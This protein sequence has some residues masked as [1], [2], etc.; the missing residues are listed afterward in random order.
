MLRSRRRLRHRG[1]TLVELLIVVAIIGILTAIMIP[2]LL[3]ALEKAKQKRTVSDIRNVGTSWMAW[4]TDQVSGAAAGQK[5]WWRPPNLDAISYEEL[6]N[7]LQPSSS[8]FYIAEV[9]QLDGWGHPLRFAQATNLLQ[10]HTVAIAAAC[11]DGA[12]DSPF[13]D[14]RAVEAFVTTDFDRDIV[15]SDGYFVSW[16]QN[17]RR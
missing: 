11:R 1:F 3:G 8:F 16:P 12:L 5:M 14:D 9:P 2:N 4:L 7:Y 10:N 15:W 17:L 6:A 13:P